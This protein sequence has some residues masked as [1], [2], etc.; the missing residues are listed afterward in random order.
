VKPA[1]YSIVAVFFLLDVYTLFDAR[2]FDVAAGYGLGAGFFPFWLGA[3]IAL[4]GTI[5]LFQLF[6]QD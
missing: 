4:L 2:E 3:I 5:V 6:K 1:E